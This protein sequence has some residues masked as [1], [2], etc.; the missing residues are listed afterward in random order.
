MRLGSRLLILTF[1]A[2]L[3]PMARV[4]AQS[5]TPTRSDAPALPDSL[6][7]KVTVFRVPGDEPGFELNRA[8]YV[9]VFEVRPGDGVAQLFPDN[10]EGAR[11]TSPI[12]RTYL[13][14]GRA[15]YN[16]QVSQSQNNYAPTSSFG[17][18]RLRTS[19]TILVVASD[20]PLRVGAPASTATV[21]RRIE[22]LRTLRS[23]RVLVE[24]LLAIVEA[25]RPADAG[26]EV[27]SDVLEM[28]PG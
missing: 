22:R 8:A 3:L 28:P 20:R 2:T 12:G 18:E 1:A 24:D 25:V 16:R 27:V 14:A 10:T 21:L 23:G 26:A 11:V 15:H 7:L 17:T 19:R 9:A 13:Q 5:S 6:A 4:A